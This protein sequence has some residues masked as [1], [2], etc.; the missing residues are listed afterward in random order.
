M[1]KI[2]LTLL[3]IGLSF[4]LNASN[5][6]NCP[7]QAISASP[8]AQN[9]MVVEMSCSSNNPIQS[10]TNG[11]TGAS[12]SDNAF[13]FDTSTDHGKLTLSSLLMAFA[14]GKQV[15]ASTYATCPTN[16]NTA[17]S[18]YGFKVFNN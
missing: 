14:S 12:I 7:I 11:C 1:K 15:Y 10:G 3:L 2:L 16:F 17:P 6:F 18:L 13:V 8:S 5:I 9:I 4:G